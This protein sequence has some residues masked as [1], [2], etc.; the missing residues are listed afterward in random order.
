MTGTSLRQKRRLFSSSSLSYYRSHSNNNYNNGKLADL[1]IPLLA[2][3]GLYW[4]SASF[5]LA[6]RS[7]PHVSHCD[8]ARTLLTDIL[9]LT[10]DET[11]RVLGRRTIIDYDANQDVVRDDPRT[12]MMARN[13]CWLPRRI[14]SLVILVVDALR[15]D[16]AKHHLPLSVGSRISSMSSSSSDWVHNNTTTKQTT[17]SQL[18][19][20]VADPPTVTMQRLKGLTTGSLPTF[21]DI[22]GN[23][24]RV[25]TTFHRCGKTV[26]GVLDVVWV[27]NLFFFF[28]GMVFFWHA[29]EINGRVLIFVHLSHWKVSVLLSLL[30]ADYSTSQFF[31][32]YLLSVFFWNRVVHRL[33]KIRGWSNSKRRRIGNGG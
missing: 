2:I 16:F 32:H 23:M 29:Y 21:A 27:V 28:L 7:L 12:Q 8:E 5:F 26:V 6:K 22:S 4:F 24:V 3:G 20:F 11:T 18:L 31:P 17:S 30:D 9:S 14:D 13:G 10:P 15:F 25:V 33:R 19:Q 1:I